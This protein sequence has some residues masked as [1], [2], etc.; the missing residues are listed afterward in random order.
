[1]TQGPRLTQLEPDDIFEEPT[2]CKHRNRQAVSGMTD[3]PKIVCVNCGTFWP[4]TGFR[5]Y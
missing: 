2:A 5:E 4:A 3:V 1:M